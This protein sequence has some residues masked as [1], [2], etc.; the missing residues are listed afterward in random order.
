M[1]S[2]LSAVY[3]AVIRTVVWEEKGGDTSPTVLL[4][5]QNREGREQKKKARPMKISPLVSVGSL[6]VIPYDVYYIWHITLS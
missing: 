1:S 4:L 5:W 2:F 3:K 6:V